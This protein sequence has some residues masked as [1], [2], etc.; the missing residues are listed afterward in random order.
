MKHAY[1]PILAVLVLTSALVNR[2]ASQPDTA[3]LQAPVAISSAPLDH[4]IAD[5]SL[6]HEVSLR[7]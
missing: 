2:D 7:F 3:T 6:I 1:I 5:A 4:D